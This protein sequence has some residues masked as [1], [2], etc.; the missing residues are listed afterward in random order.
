MEKMVNIWQVNGMYNLALLLFLV[1]D[2]NVIMRCSFR[3]KPV[4]FC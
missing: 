1:S 3:I 4:W 2:T